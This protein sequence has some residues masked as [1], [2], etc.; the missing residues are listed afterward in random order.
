MQIN[1]SEQII[2]SDFCRLNQSLFCFNF[3]ENALF[4]FLFKPSIFSFLTGNG[5]F[6]FVDNV[7]LQKMN[8]LHDIIIFYLDFSCRFG[9]T[10][11]GIRVEKWL[12]KKLVKKLVKNYF[13]KIGLVKIGLWINAKMERK[14]RISMNGFMGNGRVR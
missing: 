5:G 11:F 1:N 10:R 14:S 12:V 9:Q 2:S 6:I 4:N 3:W 13:C 7:C 8:P